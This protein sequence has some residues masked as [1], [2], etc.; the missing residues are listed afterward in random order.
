MPMSVRL[1]ALKMGIRN[2]FFHF[3]GKMPVERYKLYICRRG[4]FRPSA[5]SFTNDGGIPSSP[6][7]LFTF[8]LDNAISMSVISSNR[9][10]GHSGPKK[11]K[12]PEISI[13]KYD[14]FI[15]RI[16][17]FFGHNSQNNTLNWLVI[18]INWLYLPILILSKVGILTGSPPRL[19]FFPRALSYFSFRHLIS[20]IT[21]M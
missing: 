5:Q 14:Q 2:E 18:T 1:P 3:E 10:S 16:S 12:Q 17:Q 11:T 19:L 9:S 21:T 20:E 6:A 13:G 7:P 4:D 15:A 8:N